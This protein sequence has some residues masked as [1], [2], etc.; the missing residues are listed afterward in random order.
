MS[1][2]VSSRM[3]LI[4]VVWLLTV[5]GLVW[6][7]QGGV[8]LWNRQTEELMAVRE[9]LSRVH[10]WLAVEQEVAAREAEAM[11]PLARVGRSELMWASLEGLQALAGAQGL[12]LN[13]L[14]PSET[15]G[16]GRRPGTIRL[17]ARLEGPLAGIGKFLQ[18]IPD[19]MPGVRL[20]SLQFLPQEKGQVQALLRLSL[21][22]WDRS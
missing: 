20:E 2:R 1:E 12:F 21:P 14:R 15:A 11:G 3:V 17:D 10:G 6:L 22:A 19:K 7:G 13:D 4:A 16:G 9:R 18:Q 8:G 5:M